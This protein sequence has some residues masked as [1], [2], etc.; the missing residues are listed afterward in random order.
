M[1]GLRRDRG[2]I[3]SLIGWLRAVR[4]TTVVQIPNAGD[5]VHD[6]L[7]LGGLGAITGLH[8]GPVFLSALAELGFLLFF[9]GVVC[10][11]LPTSD[12]VS[13]FLMRSSRSC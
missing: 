8:A 12:C 7:R 5:H 13:P 6:K 3:V 4:L 9:A 2:D 11:C 1:L 10:T